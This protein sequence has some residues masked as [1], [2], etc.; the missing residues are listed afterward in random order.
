[1]PRVKNHQAAGKR[2]EAQSGAEFSFGETVTPM[3]K[4]RK[5]RGG[6]MNALQW[7]N[8]APMLPEARDEIVK[9]LLDMYRRGCI[10]ETAFLVKLVPEG[11]PVVDKAAILGKRFEDFRRGVSSC[12]MPVG[13]LLQ[14][15]IGHGW[16]PASKAN[17]TT[18]VREDGTSPS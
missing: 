6:Q 5:Q 2:S 9:D 1:M 16:V 7:L 10:T 13:I 18:I 15:T 4:K 12:D 17:F 14:A 3:M 11:N 8:I